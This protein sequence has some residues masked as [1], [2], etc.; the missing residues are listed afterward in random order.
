MTLGIFNSL[1]YEAK[2]KLS[3]HSGTRQISPDP[4]DEESKNADVIPI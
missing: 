3:R 4:S 1:E 2:V